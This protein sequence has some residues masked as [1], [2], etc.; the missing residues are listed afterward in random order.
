MWV[1]LASSARRHTVTPSYGFRLSGFRH[2]RPRHRPTGRLARRVEQRLG[3]NRGRGER[4]SDRAHVRVPHRSW[5][6]QQATTDS[7]RPLAARH[8]RPPASSGVLR[9][10]TSAAAARR[11]A[12]HRSAIGPH[13][14]TGPLRRPVVPRPAVSGL[15]QKRYRGCERTSGE[16]QLPDPIA[17][18]DICL[19]YRHAARSPEAVDAARHKAVA[20]SRTG[21]WRGPIRQRRTDPQ[22]ARTRRPADIRAEPARLFASPQPAGTRR[23]V[24]LQLGARRLPSGWWLGYEQT[25]LAAARNRT[26][27]EGW[28]EGR[29][30]SRIRVTTTA[31]P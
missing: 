17:D 2:H 12:D 8:V 20:G 9:P 25:A 10:R 11:R 27:G 23:P 18:F 29:P 30:G 24:P 3:A 4:C 19:G 22:R 6:A 13:H 15:R 31:E 26:R 21:P 7:G 1:C 28:A 16:R 14:P 5:T